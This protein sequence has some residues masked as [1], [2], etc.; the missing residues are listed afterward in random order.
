MERVQDEAGA[1]TLVLGR[2]SFFLERLDQGAAATNLRRREQDLIRQ[3]ASLEVSLDLEGVRERQQSML[4]Y[5]SQAI[6]SKAEF[7]GLEHA[8]YPLRVD[9]Q[10]LTLVADTPDGPLP[11]ERMGSGENWVG[12][13]L[14]AHL[15]M[16]Q[17][18][19]ER[20]RP[21]PRFLVI[22]QPSQVYFPPDREL[23]LRG[24]DLPDDDHAAVV[25]LFLSVFTAVEDAAKDLSPFQ[26]LITEHA[27]LA[28]DWYQGA[29]IQR[30]R[31][32]E[33]LV[34]TDWIDVRR[35]DPND[36]EQ[37]EDDPPPGSH[38]NRDMGSPDLT[39]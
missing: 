25:R 14:A 9:P 37:R 32:G 11:M 23:G 39:T 27:D 21:L 1:R 34:P 22:D 28:E 29:V 13:H 38:G 17:F 16:H 7:L 10:R 3:I 12:Y 35:P 31:D 19:A 5:V 26:L 4:G 24:D 6:G 15:S 33:R 20:G 2:I 18:F 30:W 8:E 36:P